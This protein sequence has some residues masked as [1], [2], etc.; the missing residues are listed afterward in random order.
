MP[1]R[2]R[3]GRW[4]MVA[5]AAIT[6]A[7]CSRGSIVGTWVGRAG[8]ESVVFAFAEDGTGYRSVAGRREPFT[9]AFTSGYPG[10]IRITVNRPGTSEVRSGL[11]RVTWDDRLELELGSPGGPAPE[12]LG[13][14]A[15][16]LAKP[17][18]R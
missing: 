18:V 10:R 12:Q 5:A 15:L 4:L 3:T 11:A 2:A 8:G 14:S 16:V 6:L 7:A 1:S 13:D 17:P 9:Y